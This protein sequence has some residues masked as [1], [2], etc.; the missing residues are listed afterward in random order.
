MFDTTIASRRS[1]RSLPAR[2]TGSIR[3]SGSARAGCASSASSRPGEVL[4]NAGRAHGSSADL[5]MGAAYVTGSTLKAVVLAGAIDDGVVSPADR[6]DCEH[7]SWAVQGKTLHDS[8]SYGGL[9]LPEMLQVSSN[10]EF[11][12][13]FFRLGGR[14]TSSW[15]RAFHFGEMPAVDGAVAGWIPEYIEDDSVAGAEV[16]IGAKVTASPLQVAAAYGALA[17][18]GVYVAPTLT[19]R[20]GNSQGERIMKEEAAHV[21][22]AMLEES[23]NGPMATG[24]LARIA[25]VRVAGKTGTASWDLPGDV[26]GRY[27]SFVGFVPVEAPRFVILVGVEKPKDDASGGDVAAPVFARVAAHALAAGGRHE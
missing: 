11:A 25:G 4:A 21:V 1:W 12:K 3:W 13:I 19:V 22:A 9:S 16:A 20:E 6:V 7:G 8:G 18:G 15:L 27:A 24:K 10:I 2:R 17:N 14:R 23:V 26:E 5:G